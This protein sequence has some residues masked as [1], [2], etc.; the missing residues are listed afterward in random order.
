MADLPKID[1]SGLRLAKLKGAERVSSVTRIA[2][3]DGKTV[4]RERA[5]PLHRNGVM[6]DSGAVH[7]TDRRK[8]G[9]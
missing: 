8:E 7:P 1:S 5:H 2:I 4:A 6:N 9:R 3:Q